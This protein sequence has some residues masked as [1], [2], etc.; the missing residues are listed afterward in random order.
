MIASGMMLRK[1]S[2][3]PTKVEGL[4]YVAE[5]AFEA[6]YDFFA[7]SPLYMSVEVD[8]TKSVITKGVEKA[9]VSICAKPKGPAKPAAAG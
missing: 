8:L 9:S 1:G 7:P 5:R 3:L 4:F 2:V 6:K